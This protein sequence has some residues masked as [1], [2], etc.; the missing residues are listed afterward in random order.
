MS[1]EK[2]C[3]LIIRDMASAKNITEGLILNGYSSEVTPVQK[4]YKAIATVTDGEREWGVVIYSLYKTIEEANDGIS[5]FA[6]HGYNIVK[7]WI[8]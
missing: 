6:A 4:E 1:K 5:R 3:T 8:E 7:A 2:L